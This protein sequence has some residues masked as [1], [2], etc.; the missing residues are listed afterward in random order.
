MSTIDEALEPMKAMLEAE[1][2]HLIVTAGEDALV[3][4]TVEPGPAAC[5]YCLVSKSTLRSIA[6]DHLSRAGLPT[7]MNLEITYPDDP[8]RQRRL[9]EG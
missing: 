3:R 1:D 2:Y 6:V 5:S 9:A 4:L 7:D 8:P